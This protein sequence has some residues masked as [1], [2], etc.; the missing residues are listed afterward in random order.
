MLKPERMSKLFVVGSKSALPKVVSRLHELKIAHLIE[1]K[2]GEFDL[3]TPLENFEKLSGM[4][5]HVRSL[6]SHLG[7]SADRAKTATFKIKDL[8]RDISKIREDV[9]EVIGKTKKI[10]DSIGIISEQKKL[11]ESMSLLGIQPENFLKSSYIK[12]FFGCIKDENIREKLEKITGRFELKTSRHGKNIIAAV[13][14]DAGFAGQFAKALAD[15]S[16]SDID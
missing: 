9:S 10:E 1:H 4:L 15:S 16:F 11:L 6:T 14:V 8:E 7:I 5:V 12:S 13:F 2:K 3:C